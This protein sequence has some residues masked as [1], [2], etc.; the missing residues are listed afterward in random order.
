M[1]FHQGMNF[2]LEH[3][4]LCAQSPEHLVSWYVKTLD[5]RVIFDNRQKPPAYLLQVGSGS[6]I[7]IY[8][9][10]HSVQEPQT[11]I[12]QGLR[13][14]A[15]RVA[16]LKDAKALLEQRGVSFPDTIKPA[17]GGGSVLFFKDPE[18]HLLHLVE[19]PEESPLARF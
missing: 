12:T 13:H 14:L 8:P 18:G 11:N 19:R 15:I 4:G 9:A 10:Q 5:A 16:S 7:E 3:I 2:S 6:L 1:A 17:G